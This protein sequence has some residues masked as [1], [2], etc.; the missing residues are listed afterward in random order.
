MFNRP[1]NSRVQRIQ[2]CRSHPEILKP[3]LEQHKMDHRENENPE[4]KLYVH[5]PCHLFPL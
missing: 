1:W 2:S 4:V 5:R 3:R